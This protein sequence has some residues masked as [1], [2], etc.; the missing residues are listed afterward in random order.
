MIP[1]GR[2]RPS[3]ALVDSRLLRSAT[4]LRRRRAG[5]TRGDR[6]AHLLECEPRPNQPAAGAHRNPAAGGPRR[7]VGSCGYHL[8]FWDKATN[9]RLAQKARRAAL[10]PHDIVR[11]RLRVTRRTRSH[12]FDWR[13]SRQLSCV[14]ARPPDFRRHACTP[15]R[16]VDGRRSRAQRRRA[17]RSGAYVARF[18]V[19]DP[20]V[21]GC[22]AVSSAAGRLDT[23]SRG[24]E[25]TSR[26]FA[27][28]AMLRLVSDQQRLGSSATASRAYNA[29]VRPSPPIASLG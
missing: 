29:T 25:H 15:P 28:I 7:R 11:P 6:P 2:R 10:R 8:G 16:D 18:N 20:T 27:P 5:R 13:S 3:P 21:T 19:A 26:H 17:R 23:D 12:V 14:R 4:G 9:S 22:V 1:C 24:K